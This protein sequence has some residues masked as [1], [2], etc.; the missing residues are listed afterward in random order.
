MMLDWLSVKHGEKLKEGSNHVER[1]LTEIL[2]EGKIKTYD[3][4][5]TSKT[6][7]VGDAIASRIKI[8]E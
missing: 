1:A 4:G 8:L 3:L 2:K 6:T 5:G 7:E